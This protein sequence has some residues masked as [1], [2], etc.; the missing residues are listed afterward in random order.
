VAKHAE[1]SSVS[2]GSWAVGGSAKAKT[3][4]RCERRGKLKWWTWYMYIY[5]IIQVYDRIIIVQ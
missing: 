3:C 1:T 5:K 4:W 2:H